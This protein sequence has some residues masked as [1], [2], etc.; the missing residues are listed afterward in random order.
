M[1]TDHGGTI[2]H[3]QTANWRT[4]PRYERY[5]D[6][7]TEGDAI[8]VLLSNRPGRVWL[9]QADYQRIIVAYGA[10]RWRWHEKLGS[11]V[12]RDRPHHYT[13]VAR[14]VIGEDAPGFVQYRDDD[15][16]NLRRANLSVDATKRP[17]RDGLTKERAEKAAEIERGRAERRALRVQRA[18][19]AAEALS[20]R[21]A[22]RS[23]KRIPSGP[24]VRPI[25]PP[26]PVSSRPQVAGVGPRKSMPVVQAVRRTSR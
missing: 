2:P 25:L 11:V 26:P 24:A 1:T 10:V 3:A 19:K 8:G 20:A 7:F 22:V 21:T 14:L 6:K 18:A 15:R 17:R 23:Q 13:A 4:L 16:L 9:G 5:H 12:L